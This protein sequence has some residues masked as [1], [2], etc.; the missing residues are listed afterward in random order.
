MS[1][2]K[3]SYEPVLGSVL[4]LWLPLGW[5][6]FQVAL[7]FSL[8]LESKLALHAENGPHE[9]L[10]F[11]LLCGGFLISAFTLRNMDRRAQPWL[12]RW[13]ALAAVCCFYVAGEEM[14]WGQTVMGWDTP[15]S[16]AA[17][18]EQDETN[19][20][21]TSRWLNHKPR[22]VLEIGVL[23]A[24]IIIPLAQKLRPSLVPARFN[25]IYAPRTLMVT[26]ILCAIVKFTD[27]AGR[28]LF[29][30]KFFSR[31]SEV[32]ELYLF[33][34]VLL[35]LLVMKSRLVPAR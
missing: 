35:Y 1:G 3:L 21:N 20:H 18:N 8:P 6:V 30:Y 32:E 16:W 28:G 7:E 23:F 27:K 34:F 22:L 26:A 5:M 9:I 11:L 33:Y 14:S 31:P 10:Q 2:E 29:D 25:A 17:I 24:G 12:T 13:I 19:L 4:W 15:E